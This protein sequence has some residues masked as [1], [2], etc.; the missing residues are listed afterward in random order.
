MSNTNN[1]ESLLENAE[2]LLEAGIAMFY[3]GLAI[4]R[5]AGE[6]RNEYE[7]MSTLSVM[8]QEDRKYLLNKYR[9]EINTIG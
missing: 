7:A 4:Y 5:Q 6:Y 8:L 1:N 2:Q 3:K 9:K